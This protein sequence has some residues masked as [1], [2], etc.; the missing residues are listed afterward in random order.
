MFFLVLFFTLNNVFASN[1]GCFN[2]KIDMDA[3]Y[4]EKN[5]IKY[6][7]TDFIRDKFN[8]VVWTS[9]KAEADKLCKNRSMR[10]PT[11]RELVIFSA[12]DASVVDDQ[13]HKWLRISDYRVGQ[14]M[15]PLYSKFRSKDDSFKYIK[16]FNNQSPGWQ[17]NLWTDSF[18]A[19]FNAV[20]FYRS[21]FELFDTMDIPSEGEEEK[22]AIRC[23][24]EVLPN[25]AITIKGS[26]LPKKCDDPKCYCNK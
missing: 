25:S 20:F 17:Y 3:Y 8:N 19:N 23:V 7:L 4:I 5:G 18:G 13:Q 21:R 16:T 1:E 26:E 14:D 24:F 11:A 10:L 15:S 12:E 9:D 6:Y 22:I 2:D